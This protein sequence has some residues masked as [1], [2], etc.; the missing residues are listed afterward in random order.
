MGEP[1]LS[2]SDIHEKLLGIV[3][4]EGMVDRDRLKPDAELTDL[5]IESADFVMILMAIEEEFDIY[6]SVDNELTDIKTVGDL[7]NV[8]TVK[9]FEQKQ[10]AKN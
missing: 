9:Y 1:V 10:Q 7:L 8:F 4:E 5:E 6:L 2:E 3:A